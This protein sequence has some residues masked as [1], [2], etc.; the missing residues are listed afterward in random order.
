MG[1]FIEDESGIELQLAYE[2]ITQSVVD[3]VLDYEGCPYEVSVNLLLTNNEGITSINLETRG[4]DNPTDVLSFPMIEYEIPG[5]FSVVEG[6]E[7]MYFEPDTGQLLLGDIVISLDK[8][9]AQ[10]IEYGHTI[11]REFAFLVAHS[12]FHLLGYDHM[13]EVEAKEMEQKQREVLD[14]L[15]IYR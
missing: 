13:E 14:H 1:I 2:K 9:K 11:E 7:A 8:V 10:A 4:I 12:M 3:E 15:G 6:F 5:D